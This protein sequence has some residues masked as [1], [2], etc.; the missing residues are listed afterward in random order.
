MMT[1]KEKEEKVRSRIQEVLSEAPL[2][3]TQKEWWERELRNNTSLDYAIFFLALFG[4]K[5]SYDDLK[6]SSEMI[7]KCL[8]IE[9]NS[10]DAKEA[11]LN[12]ERDYL[13]A[14]LEKDT[15]PPAIA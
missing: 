7:G 4:R 3:Q 9:K 1:E 14:A 13:E 8:D 12:I 11:L 10:P 5:E 6:D 2:T 15:A